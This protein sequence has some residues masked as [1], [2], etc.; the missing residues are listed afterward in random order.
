ME[1]QFSLNSQPRINFELSTLT[2]N[3]MDK[4]LLVDRK[5]KPEGSLVEVQGISVGGKDIVVMAGPCA[6][7]SPEQLSETAM[8][9]KK[10]GAA[11]LRGGAIKPR[12]SPYSFQGL[13]DK[14]LEMLGRAKEETGLPVVSEVMDTRDVEKVAQVA[15]ILL[16]LTPDEMYLLAQDAAA[17][18]GEAGDFSYDD[19]VRLATARISRKLTLPSFESW[20]TDYRESPEK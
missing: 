14:G 10:A 1:T 9:V 4:E 20:S 19:I 12:T 16:R 15:D 8:H 2:L 11:V 13:G 3:E 6:V 5:N 7:E 18:T 17:D